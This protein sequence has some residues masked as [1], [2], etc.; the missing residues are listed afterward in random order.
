MAKISVEATGDLT[1]VVDGGSVY[2]PKINVSGK[3]TISVMRG[4]LF[5]DRIKASDLVINISS[6]GSMKKLYE[7]Y[8]AENWSLLFH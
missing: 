1:I 3:L 6:Y 2:T 8:Q 5:T 4:I 7:T